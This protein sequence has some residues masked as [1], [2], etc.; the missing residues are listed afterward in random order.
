MQWPAEEKQNDIESASS[1]EALRDKE[2]DD[3]H[4]PMRRT[5]KQCRSSKSTQC[6]LLLVMTHSHS[7]PECAEST[8]AFG[9]FMHFRH[10]WNHVKPMF[11]KEGRVFGGAYWMRL[12]CGHLRVG[13]L[14]T[15]CPFNSAMNYQSRYLRDLMC[16]GTDSTN[17]ADITLIPLST[18]NK[19]EWTQLLFI[20]HKRRRECRNSYLKM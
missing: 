1:V 12:F 18:F 9:D 3:E 11:P 4:D 5:L 15:S 19:M 6:K 13:E 20:S 10:V 16:A 7:Q 17:S 8:A 14:Q 2:Q